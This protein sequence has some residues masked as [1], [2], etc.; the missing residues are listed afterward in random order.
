VREP[1]IGA[2]ATGAILY[3]DSLDEPGLLLGWGCP[4]ERN[5]GEFVPGGYRIRVSGKC[6]DTA[7]AAWLAP[8]VQGV[9]FTD[10]E[11][12]VEARPDGGNDR[13]QF[14]LSVRTQPNGDDR[15]FAAIE[16][17]RGVAQLFAFKN[18]R[19]TMLAERVDLH[20]LISPSD[21][22]SIAIRA[23][24]PVFWLM[25]NDQTVLWGRD[26]TFAGGTVSVA[27]W[28]LGAPTDD[29]ETAIVLR[30][31]RVS[32]LAP[33]DQAVVPFY[34]L[35]P[36]PTP[37]GRPEIAI[38]LA[39]Q[40][41]ISSFVLARGEVLSPEGDPQPSEDVEFFP[42][43]TPKIL[44]FFNYNDLTPGDVL[45]PVIYSYRPSG[46]TLLVSNAPYAVQKPSGRIAAGFG[47]FDRIGDYA[48]VVLK[49]DQ[50]AGKVEFQVR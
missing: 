26:A 29:Q 49:N 32:E 7:N 20:R 30:N 6:L 46:W 17:N 47:P 25:I 9:N 4:T 42:L 13:L 5:E 38:P 19:V 12:R 3:Q 16:P 11:V 2:P 18:G 28:R 22:S 48:I 27:V 10:G 50:P 44:V 36:Y 21:W 43:G 14:V 37:V 24:G 35:Q 31:L 45:K 41:L 33:G 1:S 23:Q 39:P 40:N 8:E 15:L 34:P